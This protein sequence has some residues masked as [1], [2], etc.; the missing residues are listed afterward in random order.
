MTPQHPLITRLTGDLGYPLL[1]ATGLDAFCEA[2]G[3]AVLFCGGDPAAY[4]ETLDLAV[5]LPELMRAFPGRLRAG[6]AASE[7]EPALQARYGFSR[8]PSLVFL[9]DGDYLGTLSGIL[10]WA[11]YLERIEDLLAGP[12]VRPPSIGIP[13]TATPAH[14]H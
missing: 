9:R 7:L 5:V 4:P 1:D 6:V 13:L 14:C 12:V 8:W 3:D 2:P 10:D 11:V